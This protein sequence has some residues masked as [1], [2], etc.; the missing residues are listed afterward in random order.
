MKTFIILV[1][2]G[3]LASCADPDPTKLLCRGNVYV[4]DPSKNEDGRK[5]IIECDNQPPIVI[6]SD[7]DI[8]RRM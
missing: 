1:F 8:L 4:A 5:I 6:M 3:L 2:A 7:R